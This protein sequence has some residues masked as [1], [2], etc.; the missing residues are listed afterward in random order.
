MGAFV[1][2]HGSALTSGVPFC[3][4]DLGPLT[5]PTQLATVHLGSLFCPL[6]LYYPA[7]LSLG[8]GSSFPSGGMS[9]L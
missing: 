9:F 6:T 8:P 3:D 2:C 1:S 4:I 7:W 5:K